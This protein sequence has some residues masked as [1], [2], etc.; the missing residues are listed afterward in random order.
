[1]KIKGFDGTT[2]TTK[3]GTVQWKIADDN[4][5]MH[6]IKLPNTY[7]SEQAESRL[8][9]PQHWVQSANNGKG[10]QCITYHD[11]II[12]EWKDRKYQRTIPLSPNSRN[13][14]IITSPAGIQSY[15]HACS[16]LESTQPQLAFPA[17][18]DKTDLHIETDDEEDPTAHTPK[19]HPTKA[20]K[21]S[22]SSSKVKRIL[23]DSEEEHQD[24]RAHPLLA[25]FT[26]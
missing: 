16:V 5:K 17:T 4:G 8:L 25:D 14:G 11:A 18:I 10:T 9:S 21:R 19:D 15:L 3:V 6:K 12:L 23:E 13:V 7:Y 20:T 1:M 22:P 24:D 2:T 26:K